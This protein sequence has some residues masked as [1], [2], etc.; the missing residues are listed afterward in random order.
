MRGVTDRGKAWFVR[1]HITVF[2]GKAGRLLDPDSQSSWSPRRLSGRF[3]PSPRPFQACSGL[4]FTGEWNWVG[5]A[6]RSQGA[7]RCKLVIGRVEHFLMGR[8]GGT[9]AYSPDSVA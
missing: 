7:A 9:V 1:L 4:Q 2:A 8:G 3:T 6:I 5:P